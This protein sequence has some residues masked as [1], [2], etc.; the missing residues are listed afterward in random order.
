MFVKSREDHGWLECLGGDFIGVRFDTAACIA[1][2]RL[3]I[4][5]TLTELQTEYLLDAQSHMLTPEG[6]ESLHADEIEVLGNFIAAKVVGGAYAA[7]DN[8]GKGS[9]MDPNNPALDD[10]KN[11][12]LWNPYRHDNTIRSRERGPY[13]NIFGETVYSESNIGGIN[14]EEKEG[15]GRFNPQPPS[16][17]LETAAKW[18]RNGRI[19]AKWQES[20]RAFPWGR[21]FVV[22]KD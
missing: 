6:R 15:D 10:Y 11:S 14:L 3:H 13:V 4:I 1:A 22:T 20:L 12:G 21:F 8:F 9:E 19:Q 2:L 18:M 7:M 17:A 5:A 16:H